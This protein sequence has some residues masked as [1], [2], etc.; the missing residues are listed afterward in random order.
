[1]F[2]KVHGP[3]FGIVE[4]MSYF[5]CPHCNEKTEIFSRGGG[6]EAAK[7]LEVP[8]LGEIPIDPAIREGGDHGLPIL[9]S[10]PASPQAEIFRRI[11]RNLAGQISRANATKQFFTIIQ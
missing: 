10:N 8:F 3:L 11:A 9:V 5:L 2:Q 4:N 7:K 6:Q 1:M